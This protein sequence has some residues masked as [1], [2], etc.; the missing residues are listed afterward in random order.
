MKILIAAGI[1]Y[2]DIG[3]PSIHAQKIAQHFFNLGHEI[4]VV[5]YGD[6]KNKQPFDFPVHVVSI[7]DHPLKR[8][9]KYFLILYKH[10]HK[11]HLVFAFDP[12]AAGIPGFII[13]KIRRCYFV[14]RFGGD[15]IW[16]RVVES[17]KR[18]I[19]FDEY[20]KSNLYKKD[21]PLLFFLMGFVLRG[22]DRIIVYNL[23]FKNFIKNYYLVKENRI[24]II[25]NPVWRRK[26][27]INSNPAEEPIYLYAG[28]FVKY[29]NLQMVIEVFKNLYDKYQKGKL[30]L[31]GKG[32]EESN[33]KKIIGSYNRVIKV[34]PPVE[35]EVLFDKIKN[36]TVCLSPAI[37]EFNSNFALEALSLGTPILISKNNGLSVDLEDIFEINPQNFQNIF[38][39]MELYYNPKHSL[40]IREVIK[41]LKFGH[42][43]G[44]I[45][46][47]N[48][49]L[50]DSL[51]INDFK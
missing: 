17:G 38:S 10:S 4:E 15:P 30:I 27:D 6:S 5:S 45:M 19:S 50:I 48:E 12:S 41:K 14:L 1:F 2:P 44:D 9:L 37:S 42:S 43:W 36:S 31:I 34:F 29:K 46:R 3:G 7:I 21:R 8:W 23:L 24:W 35:Q 16:E 26:I 28:R 51:N 18:F 39:K 40:E 25:K 47:E 49:A 13:S 32:P 33:L 22:A 11:T 20:Y